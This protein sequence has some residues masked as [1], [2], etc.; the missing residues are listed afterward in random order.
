M[1]K[2]EDDLLVVHKPARPLT[3]PAAP[4]ASADVA[5]MAQQLRAL[6]DPAAR[7]TLVA[8]IQARFGNA[9]AAR[10]VDAARADAAPPANGAPREGPQ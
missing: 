9:F 7:A 4:A 10:V 8:E 2:R 3:A 1:K 5:R 6:A